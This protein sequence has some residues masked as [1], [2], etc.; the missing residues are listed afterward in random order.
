MFI[1]FSLAFIV[2]LI[3]QTDHNRKQ[4]LILSQILCCCGIDCNMDQYHS[5]ENI[6]SWPLWVSQQ[7]D[8]C[9][10]KGGYILL[11]CSRMMYNILCSSYNPPIKMVAGH[12]DCQN[13]RH[14]LHH[15]TKSVLPFFIDEVSSCFI[16][17]SL[18]EKTFYN[19]PFRKLPKIFTSES[20]QNLTEE[21]VQELLANPDFTSLRSL[22]ATMTKQQ[23][24]CQPHIGPLGKKFDDSTNV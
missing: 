11:E 4:I 13:I 17:Q 19:F 10:S 24:I 22:V 23:E 14:Y 16:P 5:T 21:N 12:I 6:I 7:I 3:N 9:I 18:S 20:S 1:T 15:N 8:N 2:Y